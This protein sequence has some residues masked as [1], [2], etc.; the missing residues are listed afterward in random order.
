MEDKTYPV[1]IYYETLET[2]NAEPIAF[3][4]ERFGKSKASVT[5]NKNVYYVGF[6]CADNT[7]IYY[8]II[9]KHVSVPEIK[10]DFLEEVQLGEY[11]MYLNHSD[12][13]LP[14][15]AYDLITESEMEEIEPFGVILTSKG[16]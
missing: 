15:S 7:D 5:K 3:Y 14:I 6:Y 9:Q 1:G 16:E 8:D 10:S 2:E 11:K 4:T 13:A 12:K